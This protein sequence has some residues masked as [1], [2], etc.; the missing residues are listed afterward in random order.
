MVAR[1]RLKGK[2]KIGLR[3]GKVIDKHK[4]AKHILLE[5]ADGALDWRI[6]QEKVA[7]EAALDGIYVIRTSVTA[8]RMSAEET[9][10]GY[11][12]LG[13]VEAAF[14]SLKSIDLQVRPIHHR[15]ADRVRAHILLCVLAYYVKW[16]ML[17]AWRPPL[18]ADEEQH[19][20]ATRH[21]VA[22]AKRSESALRKA[23]TK[24]TADGSPAHSFHTLLASLA[25][26]VRNTCRRK[27]AHENEATFSLDTLPSPQQRRAMELLTTLKP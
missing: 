6:D 13:R 23:H 27:G 21:P 20:K 1:G 24:T 18:F 8:E 9:V 7:A 17:Q 19:A 12:N 4:M 15:L 16:D 25:T 2:D 10:R 22:A 11:K 3:V 26:I 5:I 14:R